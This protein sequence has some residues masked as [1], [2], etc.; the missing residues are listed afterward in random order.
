MRFLSGGGSGGMM[1]T[2]LQVCSNQAC[3]ILVKSTVCVS[4]HS[5]ISRRVN[6]CSLASF[7]NSVNNCVLS[8]THNLLDDGSSVG[9]VIDLSCCCLIACKSASLC[10]H[11]VSQ[12]CFQRG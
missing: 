9:Q 2:S 12:K 3:S 5:C 4:I 11:R 7:C 8:E 1:D 10:F 6:W